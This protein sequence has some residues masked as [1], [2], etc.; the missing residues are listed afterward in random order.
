MSK[1]IDDATPLLPVDQEPFASMMVDAMHDTDFHQWFEK[2]GGFRIAAIKKQPR[3]YTMSD[4]EYIAA[5]M[6]DGYATK[7]QAE[8]INNARNFCRARVVRYYHA[9]LQKLPPEHPTARKLFRAFC[10]ENDDDGLGLWDEEQDQ[11]IYYLKNPENDYIIECSYVE[12]LWW[13]RNRADFYK[14]ISPDAF[15]PQTKIVRPDPACT[16]PIR[17]VVEL[18]EGDD[19]GFDDDEDDL[20]FD[21]EEDLGL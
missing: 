7:A 2:Y 17:G 16:D 10:D 8:S 3:Y 18:D 9:F 20:G 12:K 15:T 5:N 13:Q 21:D 14:E 11:R 6:K 19:L 1:P 4:A